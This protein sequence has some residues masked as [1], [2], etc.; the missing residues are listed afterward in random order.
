MNSQPET[1]VINVRLT[2]LEANQFYPL[3]RE[4]AD[5]TIAPD[6]EIAD[7]FRRDFG[8]NGHEGILSIVSVKAGS[9]QYTEISGIVEG[10]AYHLSS[11]TF[12]ANGYHPAFS[13]LACVASDC[14]ID[15]DSS[16]GSG[17]DYFFVVAYYGLDYPNFLE[18]IR[19]MLQEN[20]WGCL[21][22]N[23]SQES[24]F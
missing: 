1:D 17:R 20:S 11:E 9:H 4:Q 23:Q 10:G 14:Y 8:L 16:K 21:L 7:R 2:V 22:K 13:G 6:K 19:K 5:G 12:N 18:G 3:V 24:F 15:L